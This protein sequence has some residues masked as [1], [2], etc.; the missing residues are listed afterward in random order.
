MEGWILRYMVNTLTDGFWKQAVSAIREK[1]ARTGCPCGPFDGARVTL[2]REDLQPDRRQFELL[3]LEV[4]VRLQLHLRGLDRTWL[5]KWLEER[6]HPVAGEGVGQD[7]QQC[8]EVL[9][10]LTVGDLG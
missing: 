1:R 6:V 4:D 5:A 7:P 10:R 2:S 9:R 8:Q 3:S